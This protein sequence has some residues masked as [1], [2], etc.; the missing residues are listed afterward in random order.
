VHMGSQCAAGLLCPDLLLCKPCLALLCFS[1]PQSFK[2]RDETGCG[3][4]GRDPDEMEITKPSELMVENSL[5]LLS[6]IL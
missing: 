5:G 6:W 4:R 2:W 1:F 3:S